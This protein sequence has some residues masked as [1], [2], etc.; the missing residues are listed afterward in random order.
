MA[1]VL[2][3]TKTNF[4]Q[5]YEILEFTFWIRK[6]GCNIKFDGYLEKESDEIKLS[7]ILTTTVPIDLIVASSWIIKNSNFILHQIRN[8]YNEN[9]DNS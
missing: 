8:H 9:Q 4:I 1:K 3:I 2:N 7:N 6:D 5:D